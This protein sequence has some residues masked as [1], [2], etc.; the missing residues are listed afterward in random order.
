M[1]NPVL[2]KLRYP[3]A[4]FEAPQVYTTELLKTAIKTIED[5]SQ[6]LKIEVVY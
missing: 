6:K 5:F 1:E 3:I 4:K 2:K